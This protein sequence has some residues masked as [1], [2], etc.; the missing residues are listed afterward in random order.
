MDLSPTPRPGDMR[1]TPE[2]LS[3]VYVNI[4]E[5]IR[6]VEAGY[7]T[8]FQVQTVAQS[9]CTD[10]PTQSIADPQIPATPGQLACF[11]DTR[12]MPYY[13]PTK[14]LKKRVLSKGDNLA[15]ILARQ[16]RRVELGRMISL[17][18]AINAR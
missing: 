12:N 13:I 6:E 15:Q 14:E 17:E 9:L 16:M 7:I 5:L 11:M 18:R 10:N 3:G 2:D 1:I 4:E 8:L